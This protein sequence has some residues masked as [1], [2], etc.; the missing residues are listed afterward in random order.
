MTNEQL[1]KKLTRK[2]IT[3]SNHSGRGYTS[4]ACSS[5]TLIDSYD[6]LAEEAKERGIWE[7]WCDSVGSDPHHNGHDFFA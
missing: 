7:G 5:L 6:E 1:S 3:L 2:R 4:L